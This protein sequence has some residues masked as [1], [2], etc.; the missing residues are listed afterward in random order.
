MWIAVYSFLFLRPLFWVS[1]WILILIH[2][3]PKGL[4]KKR[5]PSPHLQEKNPGNELSV[6]TAHAQ[7]PSLPLK[8]SKLITT[9]NINLQTTYVFFFVKYRVQNYRS[10][11]L[12]WCSPAD[13]DSIWRQWTCVNIPHRTR[14][15][16][17]KKKIQRKLILTLAK[18]NRRWV[19]VEC[20]GSYL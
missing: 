11:G 6:I 5:H 3:H 14:C 7:P 17:E 15:Y 12:I 10:S 13:L 1:L 16:N 2:L 4:Y 9:I 8:L 20:R 18:Q 19:P